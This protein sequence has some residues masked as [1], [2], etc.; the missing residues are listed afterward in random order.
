MNTPGPALGSTGL[1]PVSLTV[2]YVPLQLYQTTPRDFP[3]WLCRFVV[4]GAEAG[5]SER[6]CLSVSLH[7]PRP[8]LSHVAPCLSVGFKEQEKSPIAASSGITDKHN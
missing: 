8:V 6:S 4:P 7:F 3:E 5:N 1:Q 2:S